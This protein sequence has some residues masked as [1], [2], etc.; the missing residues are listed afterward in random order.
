ML[1]LRRT[2]LLCLALLLMLTTTAASWP[3]DHGDGLRSGYAPTA[4]PFT[5]LTVALRKTLDGA[6]YASPIVI[7]NTVVVATEHNTVYALDATTGAQRWGRHLRTPVPLSALPCGNIDPL[8]ITGTPAYDAGTGRVFLVTE[9][10]EGGV[11]HEIFGLD[12]STGA[13]EVNRRIE[14]PGT[15]AAAQQQRGALAVG[16]G[17]VYVAFGGLAGDCGNYR[18][19]VVSLKASGAFGATTYVVPTA[20]EGGIWAPGGPVV[21]PDGTVYVAVGNGASTSGAY[22][23]SD[24]ITRLRPDMRRLD[25]FAPTTWAQDNAVDA[26]LGSL[27]PAWTSSGYLLQAGKSGIGYTVRPGRLGGIGGQVRKATLCRA[28]GVSAATGSS[29]YLPCTTGVSRVDVFTDGSWIRRWTA[30]GVAGSPVVGPG[31]IYALGN[32]FMYALNGRT[33]A[34]LAQVV[35]GTTNRFATPALAGNRLY[36]GTLTGLVVVRVG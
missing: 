25:Y 10:I 9:A 14:V 33:G 35:V 21:G 16:G 30:S 28:F 29:V 19:A 1:M 12:L 7:G 6:V 2:R 15:T 32:G 3:V 27:T 22:D 18:G 4:T 17:N 23:G 13:V 20:R 24:S 36:V 11:H 8:G 31:A 34:Q 26:D 5:G